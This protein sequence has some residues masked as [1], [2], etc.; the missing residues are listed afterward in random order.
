MNFAKKTGFT[1]GFTLI[2]VLVAVVVVVLGCLAALSIQVS[3]MTHSAGAETQTVAV[4]LAESE[5]ER[6]KAMDIEVLASE[7]E[8]NRNPEPE[9][10]DSFGQL[11]T[12]GP[13]PVFTRTVTYFPKRPTSLST[14]VEVEVTWKGQFTEHR[15]FYTAVITGFRF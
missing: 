11:H 2:E 8:A 9:Q 13:G 5:I 10:L 15:V 1:P 4:F 7:A 6:L 12:G 3:S 14:Q